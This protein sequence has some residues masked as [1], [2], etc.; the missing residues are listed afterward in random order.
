MLFEYIFVRVGKWACLVACLTGQNE[1]IFCKDHVGP[2][3][4]LPS[5]MKIPYRCYRAKYD[6]KSNVLVFAISMRDII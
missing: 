1:N 5:F 4:F 3:C 6:Y 2:E